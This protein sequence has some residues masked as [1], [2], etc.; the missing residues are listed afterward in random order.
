MTQILKGVRILEV[1]QWWFVPSAGAALCDWG[2]EVIKVEDPRVGDPQRGLMSS[3]MVAGGS[4]VNYMMEQ[5]NRGKK[6]SLAGLSATE[7]KKVEEL[8]QAPSA[9]PK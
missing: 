2:A 5:P 6:S 7:R 3:G 4:A 8:R 1:A 9:A